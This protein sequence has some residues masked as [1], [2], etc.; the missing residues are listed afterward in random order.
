MENYIINVKEGKLKLNINEVE[1]G[2]VLFKI[3]QNKCNILSTIVY[4]QFKGNG[5]AKKLMNC[6]LE[7]ASKNNLILE[8]TC[9]YAN[10][11]FNK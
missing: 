6:I 2:Y 1:V 8:Y 9:S 7:Y 3:N 10:N 5:Y 4:D 11:Y